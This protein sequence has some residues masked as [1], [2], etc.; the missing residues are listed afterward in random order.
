MGNKYLA[1]PMNTRSNIQI[2]YLSV[3]N[4]IS[5]I[6]LYFNVYQQPRFNYNN[7]ERI[8]CKT[9]KICAETFLIVNPIL[10]ADIADN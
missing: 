10:L 6:F 3:H 7:D 1:I 8:A 9:V 2:C 5:Y 4:I